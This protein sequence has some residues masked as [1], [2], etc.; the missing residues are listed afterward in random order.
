MPRY[1]FHVRDGTD[2]PDETGTY[3]SGDDVARAEAV[4]LAGEVLKDLGGHFW[5]SG[6]WSLQ[7]VMEDGS[8]LCELEFSAIPDSQPL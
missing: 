4:V 2:I 5:D 3:L 7:V 1:F 6:N 8:Q